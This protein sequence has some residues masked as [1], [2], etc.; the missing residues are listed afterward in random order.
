MNYLTNYYRNLAE[1]LEI[2]VQQ[3]EE[4]LKKA[5]RSKNAEKLSN[6]KTR[7]QMKADE[8]GEHEELATAVRDDASN[9]SYE[10]EKAFRDEIQTAGKKKRSHSRNVAKLAK[11]LKNKS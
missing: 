4:A 11:K 8:A 10:D 5:L 9:L 2:K 6:E 3:L 1:D 7:Q